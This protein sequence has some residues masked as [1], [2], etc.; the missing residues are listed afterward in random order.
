MT[1]SLPSNIRYSLAAYWQASKSLV[2]CGIAGTFARVALPFTAILLP[3]VVVDA[4]AAGVPPYEFIFRVGII[5]LLLILFNFIK[6][7]TDGYINGGFGMFGSFLFDTRF[8]EKKITMDYEML[9]DPEIRK[10]QDKAMNACQSNHTEAMN[11]PRNLV[12]LVSNVFGFIIFGGVIAYVN[13]AVILLLILSAVINWLMLLRVRRYDLATR[14]RRSKAERK[15]HYVLK[16]MRDP[17]NAKDIRLYNLTGFLKDVFAVSMAKRIKEQNAFSNKTLAAELTDASMILLRDGA[18]YAFLIYLVLSGQIGLGNFVFVFAAI[19]GLAAWV[20]GILKS[21]SDI[22]QSGSE[23]GDLRIFLDLPDRSNT[24]AGH[25]LP[26]GDELPPGISFSKVSYTYPDAEKPALCDIDLEIKPGERIAVVGVNGAGKTTLI[27]MLCGLYAAK[28]GEIK[29]NGVPIGNFNRDEYFSLFSVVFQDIHLTTTGII[30]NI[31]SLPPNEADRER[32]ADALRL[33]G[34]QEKTESLPNKE[35]TGIV[36]N[37]DENA[38]ELSGGEKQKLAL[39]RAL[40]KNAPIIILDE[41]TAALDPIAESE[42]YRQYADLTEGKTS[43]YISHRLASTR[44]CDRIL[45]IDGQRIAEE[46]THA[47]LVALGGKYAH[48]WSIQS[49]YYSDSEEAV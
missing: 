25:P 34:L 40:Y 5:I 10:L 49:G 36:R 3:R 45:L 21:G 26:R 11:L 41:P 38:I 20:S 29:L 19:G 18:A 2:L 22:M 47:E 1:Y 46:G 37:I 44:F 27:K 7:H 13:P 14:E 42:I 48:M 8:S 15:L 9:E 43:I 12:D 4:L 32:L 31:S 28:S 30:G 33:S 6:Y 16:I 23:M 39:A 17:A 35:Y 24:A